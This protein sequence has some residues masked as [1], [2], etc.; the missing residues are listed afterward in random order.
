MQWDALLTDRPVVAVAA[1]DAHARLGPGEEP[2]RRGLALHVPS[3][4]QVFRTMSI[5]IPDRQLQREASTDTRTVLEAIRGGHV[6]SSIDAVATP[7]VLS[8]V[9]ASGAHAVGMGEQ[10]KLDGPV[11]LRVDANAPEGSTIRLVSQG[12][13]IASGGPPVL[14]YE[15][16]PES[17]AYRVEVDVPRAPG[18]PPVPWI[19]SNAI[20][21]GARPS[22]DTSFRVVPVIS[23]SAAIYTDGSASDWRIEK[24][25]RSEGSIGVVRSI[26]GTQLIFR[27][28]L[29]GTLSE[30]PYVAA[31]VEAGSSLAR[32]SGVMLTANAMNPMRLRVQLRAPGEGD[33][34]WGRSI[35]LD[36]MR[37]TLT[38]KFDELSP[39]GSVTGLPKLDEIRDLLFVVDTVNTKQGASGQVWLDEIRYVR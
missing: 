16:P 3:Y 20:Y 34:R 4:E 24:S 17:G 10:L 22:P 1:A 33:R 7:A 27:Y 8:F 13:T 9:A 19:V 11:M 6:Y 35:Y 32:F 31:V 14:E 25:V 23:E 2:Y 39:L 30:S 21:V 12:N 15:A 18:M 29:G 36:E 26:D 38:I 5:S 28:G 37:R